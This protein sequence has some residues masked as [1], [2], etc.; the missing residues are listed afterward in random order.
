MTLSR[1]LYHTIQKNLNDENDLAKVFTFREQGSGHY[2]FCLN[3]T[4]LKDE[5]TQFSAVQ[6]NPKYK[7]IGFE[8]LCPTVGRILYDYGLPFDRTVRLSVT[9]HHANQITFY[10][11]EHPA[12]CKKS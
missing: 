9:K 8:S 5:Q 7:S 10:R 11:I 6:Y 4:A 12:P 2:S 3:P 1:R